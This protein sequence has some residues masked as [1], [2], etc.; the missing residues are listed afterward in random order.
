MAWPP[1]QRISSGSIVDIPEGL[2]RKIST[3]F[4][5]GELN[6]IK[7]GLAVGLSVLEPTFT[8]R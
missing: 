8:P 4:P 3:L 2:L 5:E 1:H 7:E 6:Q